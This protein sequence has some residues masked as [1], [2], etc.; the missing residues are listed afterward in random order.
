MRPKMVGMDSLVGHVR[1][2]G[3]LHNEQLK[4]PHYK[5]KAVKL[6]LYLLGLLSNSETFQKDNV[7][8]SQ[9]PII[10]P[11]EDAL[12]WALQANRLNLIVRNFY[13]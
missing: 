1:L 12:L 13:H 2:H 6:N 7:P 5:F 9:P 3:V 11:S 10:T 8:S 4:L